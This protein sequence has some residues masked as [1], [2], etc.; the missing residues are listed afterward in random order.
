MSDMSWCALSLGALA[1]LISGT[2]NHIKRRNHIYNLVYVG[3]GMSCSI[4][5]LNQLDF[6]FVWPIVGLNF[7]ASEHCLL[8]I[9]PCQRPN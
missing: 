2:V 7:R 5:S 9:G 1:P 8:I 6:Y 4:K 3:L